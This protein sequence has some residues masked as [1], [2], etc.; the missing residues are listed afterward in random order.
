MT[1]G[2][3]VGMGTSIP[4]RTH[5]KNRWIGKAMFTASHESTNSRGLWSM[6]PFVK[7]VLSP[8]F[9]DS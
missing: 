7:A 4:A 3:A 9:I 5:G 6:S 1:P 2:V 8:S